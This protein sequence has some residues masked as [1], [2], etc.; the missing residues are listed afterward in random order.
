MH[1]T[2]PAIVRQA[3]K[4]N[5]VIFW[6][7]ETRIN[8]QAYHIAGFAQKGHTPTVPSFSKPEKTNM[9]SAISNQGTCH[10][11]CYNENLPQQLFIDFM[12]HLVKTRT[13]KFWLL[14][15]I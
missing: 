2:Y 11:L 1:E 10:F 8:N 12:Q 14:L 6:G 7:D 13:G 3:K 5:A 15:T 4:E 9:V